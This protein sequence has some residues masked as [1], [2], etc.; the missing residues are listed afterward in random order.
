MNSFGFPICQCG[1]E[2]VGLLQ[3][4]PFQGLQRADSRLGRRQEQTVSH[5]P[6]QERPTRRER[7]QSKNESRWI[8]SS[9]VRTEQ[10]TNGG[11]A[12]GF[13]KKKKKTWGGLGKWGEEHIKVVEM[14]VSGG[15]TS[16]LPEGWGLKAWHKYPFLRRGLKMM[17][18]W[19]RPGSC[20]IQISPPYL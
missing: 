18:A 6:S 4:P 9:S 17:A 13:K 20:G 12:G 2:V 1:G 10:K 11:E 3:P 8:R 19:R 14:R 7:R 15:L 16:I 5:S